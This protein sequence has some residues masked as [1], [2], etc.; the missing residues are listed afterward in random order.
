MHHPGCVV[1]R[2]RT[3]QCAFLLRLASTAPGRRSL[4]H[5]PHRR[6]PLNDG[7]RLCDLLKERRLGVNVQARTVEDVSVDTRFFREGF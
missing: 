7:Y 2:R 5:R 1:R 6:E 3:I 4:H